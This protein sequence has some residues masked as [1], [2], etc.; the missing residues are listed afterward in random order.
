MNKIKEIVKVLKKSKSVALFTHISPD[1]DALGSTFG[2]SLALKKLGKKV[3][4][5]IK[6]E[7]T[8]GQKILFEEDEANRGECNVNDFDLFICLDASAIERLGDYAYCFNDENNTLVL[9][10]HVCN[11]Y[12]AKY[13][14]IESESSSC[15]EIVYKVITAL[16]IKIDSD[17]ATKLYAGLSTDTSSFINS[18]TNSNSFLVASKLCLAGAKIQIVNQAIYQSKSL[19]SVVF[20]KH[21]LNNFQIKGECAYIGVDLKTLQE[22][23]GVKNDC[24]GFSKMLANYKEINY[25]WAEAD[26]FVLQVQL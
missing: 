7:F 11:N 1:S 9:D 19:K 6:E 23:N 25:S 8:E 24:S 21:L 14:Y 22:L 13:N 2:L 16:K 10:H 15:C 3:Q 5:F 20:K 17:I 4:I 12:I 26:I 18:N